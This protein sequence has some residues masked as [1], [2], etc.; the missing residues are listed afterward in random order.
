M[1]NNSFID[2]IRIFCHSG[3][4]GAGNTHFLRVKFNPKAGP[5]GG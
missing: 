4:G 1:E 3:K 2:Y 5:D